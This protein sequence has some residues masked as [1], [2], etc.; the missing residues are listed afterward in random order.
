MARFGVF[1]LLLSSLLYAVGTHAQTSF[2]SAN[3]PQP[4]PK[5]LGGI[6]A[7]PDAW[8]WMVALLYPPGSGSDLF[9]DQYCAGALIDQLWVLTAA[10]CVWGVPPSSMQVGVGVFDLRAPD[11]VRT[12]VAAIQVHPGFSTATLVND[13]ALVRL[14][15]PVSA[16]TLKLYSGAS[17]EAVPQ[18]LLG[19]SLTVMGWGLAD[20]SSD[21]YFPDR[22]RQVSLPVVADSYC[23]SSYGINLLSSQFCAG[24]QQVA[25]DACVGDSGGPLVTR[26]DGQWVHAGIVSYGSRCDLFYGWYGVYTR[27]SAY[28][29]FI[30]RYVPRARFTRAASASLPFLLPLLSQ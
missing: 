5:I 27:T 9:A 16:P 19:Q 13:I 15:S 17:R 8:P 24:F 12:A 10:H 21:W 30:R 22:L 1:L 6:E 26:I 7:D 11:N 2:S 25:R 4:T 20:G 14:A 28:A 29:D 18:G 3:D 23:S